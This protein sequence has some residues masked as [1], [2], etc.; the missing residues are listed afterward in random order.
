MATNVHAL[1]TADAP[2]TERRIGFMQDDQGHQSSMRLMCMMALLS[3]IVFGALS[4][5]A[6]VGVIGASSAGADAITITF[7][8]LVAAFAPKAI[9][10]FAE[11]KSGVKP[12]E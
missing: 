12:A 10:K 3:A 9:Q 1:P 5:L 4:I 6:A 11:Q 2:P 7:G 8:F